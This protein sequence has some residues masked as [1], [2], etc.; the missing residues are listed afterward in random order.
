MSKNTVLLLV[1]L[2]LALSCC[3]LATTCGTALYIFDAIEGSQAPAMGE[4][5]TPEP[6]GE[7]HGTGSEVL[8]SITPTPAGPTATPFPTPTPNPSV[9][10]F[11]SDAMTTE[12][13][14]RSV[15]VP[16]NDPI[17]LAARLMPE[18]GEVK[19]VVNDVP[20]DYEE[21]DVITFWISNSDTDENW[22]I[23]AELAVKGDH[24]YMWREVGENVKEK[25][26]R[27]AA[28]FFD[29]TIYPTDREFFGSEWTPG[30]DNDPRLHVLHASNLGDTIA[31]YYSSADEIPSKIHPFSNE[32]EMFYINV[33]NNRPGSRFYNGTL[34]HEFQHMIHWYQDKNE[35]TWMNEGASE[36]AAELNGLGRSSSMSPESAFADDPDLQLNTWPDSDE[37]YAHYG[38]AYLFMRYF[39][40]RFGEDATKAL[41][42]NDKN[43]MDAVDDVLQQIG[44]G[45]TADDLFADWVIANWLDDASLDDGRWGYDGYHVE[46]MQPVKE[47]QALP[48]FYSGDVHQYAADYFTFPPEESLTITFD[49]DALTHLAATDAHSGDWAWWSNR[50]DESDTRLTFPVDLTE[51]DVATL[52]FFTWYDI[53]ELWDYAYIEVSEDGGRTWTTLET[54]RTTTENPNGNAFGPGYTGKSNGATADWVEEQVD[55]SP[56]AGK[57]ILV[58][59]EYVTDAAVTEPGM[60]IDSVSIPEIDY[61]QDFENGPNDWESEGWLLTNNELQQRWSVQVIEPLARGGDV[62]VHRLTIDENGHGELQL[63]GVE[64][65]KDLTLVI[66]ALAPV[67]VEPASYQFEITPR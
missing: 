13:L 32:K 24:V 56:Y 26:L 49:G 55:L 46:E 11:S 61:Y 15:E 1:L 66:S 17:D 36:L 59:F 47:F 39:L 29:E 10:P 12:E 51:T 37:S 9:T 4:L 35:S 27:K 62:K 44:A 5:T 58:R 7:D 63:S 18:L 40:S 33:D 53:E 60:F 43:G 20:V 6:F 23:E 19:R 50:V 38:N 42:A 3:A 21:G 65:K 45:M 48:V 2:A 41:V 28:R 57:E 14:L 22:Q 64:T 54:G 25:D 30:I 67:T 34:A 8:P 31:G 52:H 16:V